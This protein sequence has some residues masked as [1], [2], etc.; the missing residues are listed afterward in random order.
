[1]GRGGEGHS[2]VAWLLLLLRRRSDRVVAAPVSFRYSGRYPALSAVC[3]GYLLRRGGYA[4]PLLGRIREGWG[5]R[6][7][8]DMGEIG[9]PRWGLRPT[10]CV[11]L[12]PRPVWL[13]PDGQ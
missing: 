10:R 6:G 2:H 7:G 8:V 12:P 5:E 9:D 1:V 4:S 13:P 3:A 11:P